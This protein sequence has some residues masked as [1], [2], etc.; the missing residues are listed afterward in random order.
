MPRNSR[1]FHHFGVRFWEAVL[2]REI[3]L[4]SRSVSGS[5]R[6]CDLLERNDGGR[7]D[8]HGFFGDFAVD[9]VWRLRCI[10]GLPGA[11]NDREVSVSVAIWKVRIIKEMQTR[12]DDVSIEIARKMK[13]ERNSRSKNPAA[14]VSH[15][16]YIV[17][18]QTWVAAVNPNYFFRRTKVRLYRAVMS[19]NS[20]G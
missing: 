12:E 15:G 9:D 3:S 18:S 6:V 1:I 14:C 5:P 11:V 4:E 19:T 10:L 13:S 7:R 17:L 16:I 20:G 2:C 8:C